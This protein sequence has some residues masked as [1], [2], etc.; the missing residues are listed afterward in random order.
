M[1]QPFVVLLRTAALAIS[2]ASAP[3]LAESLAQI[4]YRLYQ[5][6][7]AEVEPQLRALATRGDRDAQLLLANRL[8]GSADA[9]R[10]QEAIEL[11]QGV[12][13]Q[14]RGELSALSSLASMLKG[15]IHYRARYREFFEQAVRRYPQQRDFATLSTTLEVFLVYPEVFQAERV[16]PLIELYQRACIENCGTLLYRGALAEHAGQTAKAER[17]YRRAVRI[18]ARAVERYYRI[19]GERQEEQFPVFAKSLREG[20]SELPLPVVQSIGSLLSGLSPEQDNDT[21]LWLNYAIERGSVA[22]MQSKASYM[23]SMAEQFAPD[24]VFALIDR[25]EAQQSQQG[26]ALR[27]S[28]YLVR[29]WPTLD[30]Y[31]AH[32]LILGLLAEGYQNAYL[33]LGELHS[34]GG[35]DEVDQR[36]ALEAYQRLAEKGFASA[37]YRIATLYAHGKGICNDKAKAYAYARIAVEYGEMGARKFLSELESE[38]SPEE[39]ANAEHAR[40]DILKTVKI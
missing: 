17:Y 20:M 1:T 37:F 38:I 9:S 2:L 3:A 8:A 23:M 31:K 11:Y 24:E 28:A 7:H 32:E 14:G 10:A 35:L 34:M 5:D 36:Q 30:P 22:A 27:A 40:E 6:P 26:R 39:L 16:E 33:N 4:R 12:F 29:N 15:N 21:L 13:D 19:L 18:D 25:I